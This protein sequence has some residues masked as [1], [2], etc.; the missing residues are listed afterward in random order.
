MAEVSNFEVFDRVMVKNFSKL[1]SEFNTFKENQ[2][3][4]SAISQGEYN[5]IYLKF[6]RAQEEINHLKEELQKI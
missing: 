1:V 4:G 2:Q 5:E 6:K 3:Y